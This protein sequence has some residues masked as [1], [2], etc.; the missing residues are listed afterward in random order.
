MK[1]LVLLRH[2]KSGKL[3]P[4][5]DFERTIVEERRPDMNKVTAA[6]RNTKFSPERIL[7]SPSVRTRQ[8]AEAFCTEYG[9]NSEQVTYIDN[10]YEASLEDIVE[11]LKTLP[12]SVNNVVIVGHN[13][14]I[15]EAANR[16]SNARVDNVPTCGVVGIHFDGNSWKEALSQRGQLIFFFAPKLLSI[17]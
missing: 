8:T 2:I 6:L 3:T 16:L 10:L 4:V 9:L 5:P 7:S 14:S 12:D 17:E 15:T 13:P 11:A 1:T